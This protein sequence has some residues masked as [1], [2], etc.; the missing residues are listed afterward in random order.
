MW[1]FY[2]YSA[3]RFASYFDGSVPDA[4]SDLVDAATW[5]DGGG[6][7]EPSV[8]ARLAA[9][10]TAEGIRYE[11]MATTDAVAL[12]QLLPMLFAP[13][14]LAEKWEVVPESPDGLHPWVVTELLPRATGAALLPVLIGGRRFGVSEPSLCEY[15]FLSADECELIARE[16]EQALSSGGPWSAAWVPDVVQECLVGP[17]RSA[18]S[19]GRPLFGSLG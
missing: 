8:P 18:I 4:A 6:W 5:D 13:E 11:G 2:S 7:P 15:C 17:L 19:K 16:A 12:D 9:L 3:R 1:W 14:G 10:I